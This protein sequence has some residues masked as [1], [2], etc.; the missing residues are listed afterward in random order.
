MTTTVVL[1]GILSIVL[2]FIIALF[3]YQ[4]WKSEKVYWALTATRTLTLSALFLVLIN[5]ETNIE[6]MIILNPLNS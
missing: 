4:P 3:Q 2:A 1:F 5:P 6:T